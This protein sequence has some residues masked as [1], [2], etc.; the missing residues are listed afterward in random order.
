MGAL[1]RIGVTA[2]LALFGYKAATTAGEE[3]GQKVG[4]NVVPLLV[5]AAAVVLVY[6]MAVR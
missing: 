1:A 6:K 4:G 2:G 5:A 3:I